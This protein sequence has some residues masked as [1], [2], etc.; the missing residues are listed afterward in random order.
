MVLI[1]GDLGAGT[2]YVVG[3]FDAL[4][5]MAKPMGSDSVSE[6]RRATHA[7]A[8]TSALPS[9]RI[10]RQSLHERWVVGW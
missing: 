6:G 4:N 9:G 7:H 5:P 2:A 10:V 8:C 1:S 3:R